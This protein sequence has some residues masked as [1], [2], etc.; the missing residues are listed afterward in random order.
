M[1]AVLAV[2]LVAAAVGLF[3]ANR[4]ASNGFTYATSW[5]LPELVRHIEAGD[6]VAISAASDGG[7]GS[8]E[9]V[10]ET[11]GGQ[12]VAVVAGVP[13]SDAADALRAMGYGRLLTAEAVSLTGSVGGPPS[14]FTS[15]FTILLIGV[16]V[17]G[18]LQL[19][20]LVRRQLRDSRGRR[21]SAI[22]PAGDGAVDA[23][24]PSVRLDEVAGVDEAKTELLETIEFLRNPGRFTALG[25]R[26]VRGVLLSGP[27]GTGK[28]ML[29]KAVA[30]EAGVPFLAASGSDFVEKYVGVGARRIRDLF[31]AARREGRAVVFMDEIDAIGRRRG[32]DSGSSDERDATLNALLVEMDGFGPNDNVVVLAATNRPDVLDAAILRPGRFTRKVN[33]PM[34]DREAR[35]EILR[36]HA[37]GKPLGTDVDLPAVARKT[38]GFSGAMLA[39]LLNEAAIL[40]ARRASPI[41][42]PKDVQAGWLKVAV[43]TSRVRS[44]D[45]RER[46]II[47]AH[48]AG[49]A[50]TG[51]L[52]GEKR[53][54]EEI[55]LYAHGEALGITV[56][57]QEDNDLPSESDLQARLVALLGGRA[58]ENLLFHDVTGGAANDFEKATN[59]AHIMVTR[60]GM[61]RDP[62]DT[63]RGATGRGVL[64]SIVV[65]DRVRPS[66]EVAAAQDRAT[67][68]ILDAAYRRASELLVANMALLSRV[69]AYL[70]EQERMSGDE[71]EKVVSGELEPR[72]A[73]GWRAASSNPRPWDEI[74]GS[75]SRDEAAREERREPAV[76]TPPTPPPARERR[77]T[78][79]RNRLRRALPRPVHNAL[80][81]LGTALAGSPEDASTGR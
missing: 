56:S 20:P 34:P 67:R 41:I 23:R 62:T 69:A 15:I 44:M 79:M 53:R 73:Q 8:P 80:V 47:A 6:V 2:G 58:A 16:L 52:A 43:G 5:T 77:R 51:Y 63:S 50:V 7:D 36:V 65:T 1:L 10:A 24:I 4:P 11:T 22:T 29:A 38:Y 72:D 75:F 17:I 55:S 48:E 18:L 74:P 30:A 49:H 76:V 26:P 21:F 13:A 45:E 70:Y 33:V 27:P 19:A 42:E 9:L 68:S 25:A 54:V 14:P 3:L 32:S 31:A 28:T 59:L 60:L 66:S 71:L 35:L 57:S 37:Q 40:A 81:Q 61:G 46:S 39:D 12:R 64:S 78:G